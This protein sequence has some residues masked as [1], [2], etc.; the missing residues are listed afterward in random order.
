MPSPQRCTQLTV[1][2][3][4]AQTK[5]VDGE[6]ATDRTAGLL[7]GHFEEGGVELAALLFVE[8]LQNALAAI[9]FG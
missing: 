6:S 8:D 9:F 4:L 3:S 7:A 1:M 5:R 2:D